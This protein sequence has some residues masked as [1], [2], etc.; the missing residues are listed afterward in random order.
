MEIIDIRVLDFN[1]NMKS[2]VVPVAISFIVVLLFSTHP[3]LYFA[4]LLCIA[5]KAVFFG[6]S[7]VFMMEQGNSVLQYISW[8]FPFQLVYIILLICLYKICRV[9]L[10]REKIRA[11]RLLP[12]IC[13]LFICTIYLEYIVISYVLK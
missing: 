3:Y 10:K 5:F 1:T 11:K 13:I 12:I 4:G 8:W 9:R 2:A 6:F 7:S